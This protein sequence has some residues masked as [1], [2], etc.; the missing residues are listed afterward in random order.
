VPQGN[1][2]DDRPVPQD[3][4]EGDGP[5]E[6]PRGNGD[7]REN[8]FGVFPLVVLLVLIVGGL[9]IIFALRDMSNIQ[10]CVWSGRKNCSPIE[11]Q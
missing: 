2:R 8:P 5:D 1:L 11:R 4:P 7:E 6:E 3:E 10:D 9:F